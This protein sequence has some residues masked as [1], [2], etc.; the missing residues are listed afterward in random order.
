MN[1]RLYDPMLHRFLMPDNFVQDPY[2]TQNF[3]RYGYVLNN[4][5]KYTDPSGEFFWV[6]VGIGALIG[7]MTAGAAYV[8]HAIQTGSWNW[9]QFGVSLL[10]GA[11]IGALTWGQLPA[12]MSVGYVTAHVATG[13]IAG[14]LPSAN[15]SVG[16]WSF[17][18]SPSIALGNGL[19]AG[20][21]FL[22]SFSDGHFSFS[23]GVGVTYYGNYSGLGISG[24]EFRKSLQATWDDGGKGLTLGT[25]FWSGS[26]GMK[27]LE[28]RTGL[29]GLHS[30]DFRTTYENDGGFGIKNLGLGDRGD[31]FRTAALQL[32]W[33]VNRDVELAAGFSIFTGQP[34]KDV[35]D[36]AYTQETPFP[37]RNGIVYGGINYK[38]RSFLGGWNSE[39]N[40]NFFQ[41]GFHNLM[42]KFPLNL[43]F[44]E[45]TAHFP[46]YNYSSQ[47]YFYGGFNDPFGLPY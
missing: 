21:S 33:K 13:F 12:S 31:S 42:G 6:A 15:L 47:G 7:A 38:G 40:Q 34:G 9:G 27:D 4:P 46:K 14:L 5:L 22:A 36:G 8:A 30:G 18:V 26:G 43:I 23:G 24:A 3:N 10:G 29:L 45:P 2:N 28:Q 39:G 44:A 25:N 17:S 37:Y 35:E 20:A 16:N 19:G 11:I 1:G 32:T 41:N